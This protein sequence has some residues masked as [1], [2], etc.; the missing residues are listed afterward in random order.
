[1][2]AKK[3]GRRS[4]GGKKKKAADRT[5]RRLVEWFNGKFFAEVS[6]WSVSE[7]IY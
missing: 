7:K 6:D 3:R 5:I 1:M 4:P 2:P